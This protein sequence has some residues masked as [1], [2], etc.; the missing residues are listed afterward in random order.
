MDGQQFSITVEQVS[1][2]MSQVFFAIRSQKNSGKW[3]A[4]RWKLLLILFISLLVLK[5][6]FDWLSF[7]FSN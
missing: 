4:G 2:E 3:C 5:K 6:Q 1:I 7:L